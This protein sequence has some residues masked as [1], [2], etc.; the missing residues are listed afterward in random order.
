VLVPETVN[1]RGLQTGRFEVTAAQFAEF[2]RNYKTTREKENY[3]ATVSFEQAR[4]YVRWL[5]EKSGEA[6]RLPGEQDAAV[7]YRDRDPDEENTLDY[8]AGYSP[9]PDDA[10]RL[11]AEVKKLGG[12][13]PLLREV[14]RFKGDGEEVPVFDLGG[15]AAEWV[16]QAGG[17][18]AARGGCAALPADAR[19]GNDTP[20]ADYIG[21]RVLKGE[22]K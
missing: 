14:G 8:W 20:P 19:V 17:K 9:N 10:A 6:Y 16:V 21:L 5:S 22:K 18:G 3:P 13:A 15:N 7:L 11:L 4:E 1:Y 2:D 12:P